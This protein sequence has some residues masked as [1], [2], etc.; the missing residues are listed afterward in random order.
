MNE[1]VTMGLR[2]LF[3][4]FCLVFGVN[5]FANFLPIPEIAGEGGTLFGIYLSS[6][7]L[8]LIGILEALGGLAL[9]F[10]KFVPMA[11]VFLV[12]IMFN[13]V[14]FHILHDPAGIGGAIVGLALGVI[15]VFAHKSRFLSI[16][17]P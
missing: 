11:L 17:S 13:A 9:I 1:K 16:L 6:G 3:G 4:I 2:I 12:A 10:G 8:K 7:F 14:V 15:L 5:K